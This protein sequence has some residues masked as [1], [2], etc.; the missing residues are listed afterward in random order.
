MKSIKKILTVFASSCLILSSCDVDP[1]LTDKYPSDIIW[2]NETNLNTYINGYYSLVGG[3]YGLSEE[4]CT[5]MLKVNNP[6]DDLN[7]FVFGSMPITTTSNL[8]DSWKNGHTWQ[9]SCTRF[10][11][12]LAKNRGNF[13]EEVALRAE[14]EV[15]FF[16]AVACFNLA[17][18]YGGQ[19]IIYR[20][21][22]VLGEKNHS[23]CT[24]EEGWDFIAEDLDFAALHLPTKDKVKLGQITNAGAYGLKARAMLYA[25]RWKESSDAAAEVMEQDYAL[26]ED[27]GELFQ[28][29]RLSPVENK[30]SVIEFGYLKDK[31]SYS[32]DYFYCPP[33]DAGHAQISPTEDLVSSYQMA[34]GRD[35]DWDDP[36]MAAN[37]YEGREPR[38]Y[39]TI[40]Y[41]GCQWKGEPLYTYEGGVDGFGLGGGTTSTG[42]YMR[43]L[44][45]E[46]IQPKGASF[47]GQ[48]DLTYY[49]MR[50]AEVLL[51]YAEAM[52]MQNKLPEALDALNQ[53]RK[54]AGFTKDLTAETKTEFMKLLRHE[55]MI[56]LAFEGHRFWDLRRWGL[57]TTV[58]NG[59]NMHGVK[60]IKLGD[61]EF[62]YE[63]VDCDGG[64][65]R[66]WQE[67]YKRFPIPLDEIQQNTACEQF[68]E[69]K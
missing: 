24:V 33:S 29:S 50:Y 69:W 25:E 11:E 67:R 45:K 28:N 20:Q 12:N 44:L 63:I 5:D 49:Y 19:Y 57:S 65:T 9:L 30:E 8:F 53:V 17:K 61:N 35:F 56:E 21:L 2:S 51:I 1:V 46:A 18:R 23:L 43:K 15:R 3:Y 54:R 32:F 14:A 40:L 59:S 27:Y 10:L 22:P 41:N 7:Q 66:V 13:T 55:R 42:Y 34:D 62:K 52:A 37:P 64:K 38:F 47:T 16:R 4:A 26:Y 68:D 6:V 31:F 39:A 60:P 48:G 36:V 58:L